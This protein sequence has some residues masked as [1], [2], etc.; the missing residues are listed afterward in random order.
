M[1]KGSYIVLSGATLK[2]AQMDIISQ[3]LANA[4]TVGYK[5]DNISFHDYLV[6]GNAAAPDTNNLY[7]SQ[8]GSFMTD[9]SGGNIIK[10]GN[11]LDVAIDGS[12]FIAL[13]GGL[14][15]RRGD[16]KKNSEGYLTTYDGIK[17]MGNS[18]P[19]R[20]PDGAA[21]ISQTGEITVNGQS[22][23]T[24]KVVD[25][26]Q[27]DKLSKAGGGNFVTSEKGSQSK[28][29]VKQGYL[30]A[31]NVDVVKEMVAMIESLREYEMYQKAI[32]TFDDASAKVNNDIGRL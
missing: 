7:M 6:S 24:I 29:V 23:D 2:H 30:E 27:P 18:G 8:M 22:V 11:T 28:S 17:V 9:F 19:I 21:E 16:F 5:K 4:N 10:T 25:F 31:S 3:N 32:Q 26:K 13:E 20:L 15:T 1:N 14:Y 12:G